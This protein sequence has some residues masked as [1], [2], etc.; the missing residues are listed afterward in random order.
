MHISR[1]LAGRLAGA[2]LRR[3]EAS[4]MQFVTC[5]IQTKH[6]KTSHFRALLFQYSEREGL[7]GKPLPRLEFLNSKFSIHGLDSCLESFLLLFGGPLLLGS[8]P[9]R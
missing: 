4:K 3:N 2:C 5:T 7:G 1:A 9:F 8:L 6:N